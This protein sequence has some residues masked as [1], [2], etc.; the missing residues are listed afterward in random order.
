MVHS[1]WPKSDSETK[2]DS[3]KLY[4]QQ[5]SGQSEH[6]NKVSCNPST[7]LSRCR[8][9]SRSVRR[10]HC[11]EYLISIHNELTAAGGEVDPGTAESL[12]SVSMDRSDLERVR[13]AGLQVL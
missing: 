9:R 11:C 6:L 3:I 2:T 4:S 12:E 8:T 1:H 10:H 13:P 5:V 7:P